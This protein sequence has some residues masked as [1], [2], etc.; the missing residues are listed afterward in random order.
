MSNAVNWKINEQFCL[1]NPFQASPAGPAG[2][3]LVFAPS[4]MWEFGISS[5]FR[6]YRFRLTDKNAV[7]G[8]IGQDEF[9]VSFLRVQRK[10]RKNLVID[11]SLGGLFLGELSIEDSGGSQIASEKYEPSPIVGLMI[12]GAF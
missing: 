9:L 10:L 8:G 3:E 5:A 2:L 11:L 12:Q 6:T 7:S 4:K 1:S